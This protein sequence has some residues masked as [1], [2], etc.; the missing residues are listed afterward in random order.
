MK[1]KWLVTLL[2]A[3]VGLCA[4]AGCSLPKK[5]SVDQGGKTVFPV[6]VSDETITVAMGDVMP[7]YDDGV[8]NIYHLQ[9][10]KVGIYYHPISRLTTTDYVN[11]TDEGVI[12]NYDYERPESVDAALGTGSFIKDSNGV[13]HCFYTGHNDYGKDGGLPAK[14][15]VRH[16]ISTDGQKNWTK[17]EEFKLYGEGNPD[18]FRDPYV[19]YDADENIYNMLVTTRKDDKPVIKRYSSSS[20]D[21]ATSD[22]KDEGVFFN[23]DDGSGN[24]MECP[25][26]IEYN[27]FYYLAYSDDDKDDLNRRITHYRYRTSKDG[28]WKK[29]DRDSI[30]ANGFYAGRLE[31]AGDELYAFAW[32]AKNESNVK[33][34]PWGGRLVAHRILQSESGELS[35][36]MITSVKD[37]F[38]TQVKYEFI[39]GEELKDIS[40]NGEKFTARCVEKLGKNVTRMHFNVELYDTKGNCGITFGIDGKYEN[41]LGQGL[42]AIDAENNKLSVYSSVTSIVRYGAPIASV[43]FDYETG[44]NIGVDIIIDGEYLTVYLQ[45]TVCLTAWMPFMQKKNFAFYSN[46]ANVQIKGIECYE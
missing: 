8:M 17:I 25:S 27:G 21:A 18:D 22:W 13:Y 41:R 35:A 1:K 39:D 28:E 29:F 26:Y 7:F 2:A 20:L 12:L 43:G 16:A 40:F 45:D 6:S 31:K 4:A 44:Q 30:D 23:R 10:D 36:S 32:C 11:Y 38:S 3:T 33:P 15:V 46:G 24:N 5:N 14:E 34:F 9:D 37:A 42:V 19:Y